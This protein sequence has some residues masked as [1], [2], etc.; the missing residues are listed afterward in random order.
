[1]RHLWKYTP[2]IFLTLV[3][4]LI[5]L[6]QYSTQSQ[7]AGTMACAVPAASFTQTDEKPQSF[8]ESVL[9][10]EEQTIYLPLVVKS[11]GET[12]PPSDGGI[13]GTVT[14][15]GEPLEGIILSLWRDDGEHT[16]VLTTTTGIDGSY[17][18]VG[19]PSLLL[20][21]TYYA[22]Y[23]NEVFGPNS[24]PD[25]LFFYVTPS[26][27]SYTAGTDVFLSDFDLADIVLK[28]PHDYSNNVPVPVEFTWEKRPTT[29]DD[30]YQWAINTEAYDPIYAS[31]E[32]GYVGS[33][34]FNE[35]PAG[36]PP[37]TEYNYQWEVWVYTLDDGYGISYEVFWM[38]FED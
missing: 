33:Y 15:N 37:G 16:T 7:S 23:Q 34:W 36:V 19:L 8:K 13:Y 2:V 29:P 5:L 10:L 11:T 22:V 14:A 31:S 38:T 35:L 30:S 6:P 20:G 26:L 9:S 4:L 18:F 1:M 24:N 21:D 32:L 27:G 17:T 3:I 25:L 28:T 12:P